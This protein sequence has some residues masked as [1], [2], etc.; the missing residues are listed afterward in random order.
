VAAF[1][2]PGWRGALIPSDAEIRIE[3]LEADKR[4]VNAAADHQEVDDARE[5]VIAEQRSGP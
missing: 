4:P 2:P 1:R 3:V 5:A